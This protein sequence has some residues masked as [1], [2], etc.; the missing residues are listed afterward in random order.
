MAHEKL[1]FRAKDRAAIPDRPRSHPWNSKSEMRGSRLGDKVGLKR[2]GVHHITIP[3]GKE[4]FVFHSHLTEEEFLFVLSGRALIEIEDE[5]YQL[6]PGDFVG[7]PAP[8]VAHHVRNPFDEPF[9]YLTGGERHEV[10]IA[11]F[12]R[13]GRRMVRVGRT[14]EIYPHSAQQSLEEA[15]T[16]FKAGGRTP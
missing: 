3:P 8:S 9:V 14:I 1:I 7:F 5:T 6:E 12:P 15:A 2:I 13:H 16:D 11:D 10:E 4:S